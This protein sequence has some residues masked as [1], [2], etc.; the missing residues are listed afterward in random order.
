[1]L[2]QT[3]EGEKDPPKWWRTM[4]AATVTFKEAM[5]PPKKS[6]ISISLGERPVPY[7]EIKKWV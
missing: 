6:H 3:N 5:S 2:I 4:E 7:R 1:M